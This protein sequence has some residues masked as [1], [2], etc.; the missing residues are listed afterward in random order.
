MKRFEIEIDKSSTE[1]AATVRCLGEIDAHT[2]VRLDQTVKG[3]LNEGLC[4]IIADLG[5]VPYL[6]CAGVGVLIGS[7]SEAEQRGGALVLLNV[8]P[9][10][11][12]VLSL[13]GFDRSFTLV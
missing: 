3:L 1:R 6:S 12:E 7:K 11:R 9:A 5:K 8:V 13:L 4:Y 10:V 2:S